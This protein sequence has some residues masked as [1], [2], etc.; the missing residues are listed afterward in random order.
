MEARRRGN[1]KSRFAVNGDDGTG[2][3]ICTIYLMDPKVG[4]RPSPT[5]K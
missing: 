2:V 5:R 1:N 3:I 4:A